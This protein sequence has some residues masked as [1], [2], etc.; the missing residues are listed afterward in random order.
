MGVMAWIRLLR[1]VEELTAWQLVM[2]SDTLHATGRY[3]VSQA[4]RMAASMILP[5]EEP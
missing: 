1:R 5:K 3:D 2:L 4:R